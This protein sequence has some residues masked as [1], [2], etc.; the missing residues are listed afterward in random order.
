MWQGKIDDD[1]RVAFAAETE[2]KMWIP[3]DTD[4]TLKDPDITLKEFRDMPKGENRPSSPKNLGG[5]LRIS[6]GND[7]PDYGPS[8]GL[9]STDARAVR[10]FLQNWLDEAIVDLII[11]EG[12]V[13]QLPVLK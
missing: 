8:G 2:G 1:T 4:E 7:P 6:S 13:T 9:E 3:E 5:P 11:K 12:G 10:T